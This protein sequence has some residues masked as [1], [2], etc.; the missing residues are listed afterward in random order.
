M[1]LS[2]LSQ[3]GY[4]MQVCVQFRSLLSHSGYVFFFQTNVVT[5]YRQKAVCKARL[6]LLPELN[7]VGHI[8]CPIFVFF[9][10]CRKQGKHFRISAE[11]SPN[12]S[13][14]MNLWI[15][16]R[17]NFCLSV[18]VWENR[19]VSKEGGRPIH[20]SLLPLNSHRI[21]ITMA[22]YEHLRIFRSRVDHPP[23]FS[24]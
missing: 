20:L 13:P 15:D 14:P 2:S 24:P 3:T 11:H 6:L 7:T 17:G 18:I 19:A 16:L 22:K 8:F 12:H 1:F 4:A 10:F 23:H 21:K 9:P 5:I